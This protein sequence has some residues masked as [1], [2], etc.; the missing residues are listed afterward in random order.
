[1]PELAA[2]AAPQVGEQAASPS[3][4]PMILE[5]AAPLVLPSTQCWEEVPAVKKQCR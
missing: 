2:V 1:M 4:Q 5:V 3:L